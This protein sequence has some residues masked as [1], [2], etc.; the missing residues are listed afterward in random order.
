M[1]LSSDAHRR[2]LRATLIVAGLLVVAVM[3][4]LLLVPEYVDEDLRF[5]YWLHRLA[6]PSLFSADPLL[7]YQFAEVQ[8]GPVSLLFNKISLLYGTLY[9]AFSPVLSP[10]L[11]SK[12][13]AAPLALICAYYLFQIVA[14]LIDPFSA[15]LFTGIFVLIVS[16]PHSP[17][18]LA[19]GLPRAFTLPLLLAA[20]YY[21]LIGHY[22]GMA[23]VLVLSQ[24]YPPTFLTILLTYGVRFGIEAWQQRRIPLTRRQFAMLAIA[25]L[26]S[27]ALLL[28][29]VLTGLNTVPAA[30]N[31]AEPPTVFRSPLFGDTGRYPLLAPLALTA[32]GGPLDAGMIGVYTMVIIV[33]LIPVAMVLRR[34]FNVLPAPFWHLLIGS[35]IGFVLSWLA[36][37][38]TPSAT[39]HMPNRYLRGTL[40]I[41]SLVLLVVNGPRAIDVGS[42]LLARARGSW[43]RLPLFASLTLAVVVWFSEA[44]LAIKVLLTVLV[45]F[46]A[47]LLFALR[48]RSYNNENTE[49]HVHREQLLTSQLERNPLRIQVL[50]I[51]G[52]LLLPLLLYVQ[53]P[54]TFYRPQ[55]DRAGLVEFL[56]TLPDDALIAG[57]PCYLD[58]VPL[59]AQRTIL[60]SCET[61]SRD[62]EMMQAAL[63]AYFAPAGADIAAFC[64]SYGVDYMVVG[65]ETF[66][67]AFRSQDLILF[68]PLNGY[69][70]Q[71]LEGRDRFALTEV[72]AEEILFQ[73]GTYFVLP[74]AAESFVSAR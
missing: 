10:F 68:E 69:L 61:E 43:D 42:R 30:G 14:R 22:V 35:T 27:V 5:F 55:G 15:F 62:M 63:D 3:A 24:F 36:I 71:S 73:N 4:P 57:Y 60:F 2:W 18:S 19:T 11:F 33:M 7:G 45:V 46:A 16:L 13:L 9:A 47:L 53:S 17:V 59:Y 28:P 41:M 21:M 67:A 56:K 65:N 32:N 39:L 50:M 74:C 12:L 20:L 72:A 58:D 64:R 34:Q 44:A 49:K 37:L 48:R 25:L 31:G 51:G 66:T 8:L 6:D 70:K 26:A 23:I 29:A 40:F 38:L 54:S 52:M 1:A